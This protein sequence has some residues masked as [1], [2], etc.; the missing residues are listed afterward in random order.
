LLLCVTLFKEETTS[1]E[2]VMPKGPRREKRP[3]DVIGCAVVVAK[4]ATGEVEEI[5][6][7]MPGR[8]RSGQAGAKARAESLTED[9]RR[10]IAKL[11]AEARWGK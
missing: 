3:A 9:Q 7:G 10:E 6:R 4:I 2:Q 8:V 5:L 1:N 11:A